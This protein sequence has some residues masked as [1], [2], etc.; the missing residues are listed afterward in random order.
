MIT[1]RNVTKQFGTCIA[2][3]GVSFNLNSGEICT[4]VGRNGAGKS[5][6][7]RILAGVIKPS[8]G[9]VCVL[10]EVPAGNWR[11]RRK[12]G[13]VD[14]QSSYF[15]ELTGWEFLWWVCRLRNMPQSTA[16]KQMEEIAA[17]FYMDHK[18]NN[19][20]DAMSLGMKRKVLLAS[21]FL[22][23]PE[24]IL[25]DEPSGGLD[26]ASTESLWRILNRHRERGASVLMASHDEHFFEPVATRVIK[27]EQG[28]LTK[29]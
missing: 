25:L 16:Q 3:D 24:V 11:L 20:I 10:G 29:T 23:N 5:T 7:I 8:A 19:I 17:E 4:V 6:L 2:L 26:R 14:D 27:I 12:I 28:R 21:A 15:P 18:L 22:G 9:T 13:L 1:L